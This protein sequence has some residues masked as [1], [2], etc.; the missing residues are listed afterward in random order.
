M[1]VSQVALLDFTSELLRFLL[2]FVF[3]MSGASKLPR[4][5]EFE[6]VV[7]AYGILPE[8]AVPPVASL[9]PKVETA[10][11]LLLLTGL[12]VPW[13]SLAMGLLMLAFAAALAVNLSRRR[14]VDCGCFNLAVRRQI[15]W[16]DPIRNIALA[17]ASGMVSVAPIATLSVDHLFLETTETLPA[18]LSLAAFIAAQSIFIGAAVLFAAQNVRRASVRFLQMRGGTA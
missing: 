15:R 5:D 1:V 11:G 8:W 4:R 18:E 12:L 3:L 17:L 10:G 16:I 7:R 6:S 14:R 13:A 9:I 2:A